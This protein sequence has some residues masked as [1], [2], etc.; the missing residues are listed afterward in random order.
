MARVGTE[1]SNLAARKEGTEGSTGLSSPKR[2]LWMPRMR[3]SPDGGPTSSTIKGE[4][5]EWATLGPLKN[6]IDEKGIPCMG[7]A[8]STR[9]RKP[10]LS[11]VRS[12]LH[13]QFIDGIHAQ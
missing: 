7:R 8:R 4:S 9:T 5:P 6:L 11:R 1:A 10:G 3:M 12:A 13:A 2:Y